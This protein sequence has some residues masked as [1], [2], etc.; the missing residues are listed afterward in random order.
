MNSYIT[1]TSFAYNNL[2]DMFNLYVRWNHFRV[3]TDIVKAFK[4][5]LTLRIE[6][7]CFTCE[8]RLFA[9]VE[10]NKS[11][12]ATIEKFTRVTEA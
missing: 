7:T 10:A 1:P 9:C 11:S 6:K 8:A 3:N 2:F 5:W 4:S 12:F